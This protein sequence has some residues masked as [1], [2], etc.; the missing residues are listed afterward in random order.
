MEY[1]INNLDKY[2][3]SNMDVMKKLKPDIR[4]LA[5]Q[6]IHLP[7]LLS[8]PI[9]SNNFSSDFLKKVSR[10]VKVKIIKPMEMLFDVK[11]WFID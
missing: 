11:L 9:F 8:I 4:D 10:I 7:S 3:G 2:F 6:K 5:L 1:A